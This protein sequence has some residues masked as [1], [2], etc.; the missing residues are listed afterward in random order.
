ME[1]FTLSSNDL[2]NIAAEVSRRITPTLKQ[3]E[4]DEKTLSPMQKES[5]A[6]IDAKIQQAVNDEERRSLEME[7]EYWLQK[8]ILQ[9]KRK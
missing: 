6:I 9:N 3:L 4:R 1:N 2:K 7:R 8:Y 5:I